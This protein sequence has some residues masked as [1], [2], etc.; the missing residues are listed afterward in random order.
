MIHDL[1]YIF[2]LYLFGSVKWDGWKGCLEMYGRMRR[3][4]H[5]LIC[6]GLKFGY[7]HQTLCEH[8]LRAYYLPC[9]FQEFKDARLNGTQRLATKRPL[10]YVG[11]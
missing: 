6:G 5:Y 9:P 1:G 8:W 3:N 2:S 10:H 11:R 4:W 7:S